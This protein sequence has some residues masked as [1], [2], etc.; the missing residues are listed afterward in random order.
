[1]LMASLVFMASKAY[2]VYYLKIK[3][4]LTHEFYF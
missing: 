3:Y 4:Y 1:M 2:D